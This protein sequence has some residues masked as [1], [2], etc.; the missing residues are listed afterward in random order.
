L[1]RVAQNSIAVSAS[2]KRSR[3]TTP[4]SISEGETVTAW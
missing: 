3:L 2:G 1:S 4:F